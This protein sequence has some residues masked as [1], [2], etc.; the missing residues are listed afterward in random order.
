MGGSAYLDFLSSRSSSFAL[1]FALGSLSPDS[2]AAKGNSPSALKG[3]WAV[4]RQPERGRQVSQ[5]DK[6]EKNLAPLLLPLPRQAG[7]RQWR[8]GRVCARKAK[9]MF[10]EAPQT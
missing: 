10:P 9:A 7:E 3:G 4:G 5:L 1:Y 2:S 6:G 8:R